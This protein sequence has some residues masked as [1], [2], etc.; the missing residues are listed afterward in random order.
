MAKDKSFEDFLKV[1]EDALAAVK[2][3]IA[4]VEQKDRAAVKSFLEKTSGGTGSRTEHFEK[5]VVGYRA[6][7]GNDKVAGR[8]YDNMQPI[9]QAL[10]QFAKGKNIPK[11]LREPVPVYVQYWLEL[12]QS[13]CKMYAAVHN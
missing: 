10:A 4:K 7:V 5:M 11:K 13:E 8:I 6:I 1:Y 2:K 12:A 9:A 3:P